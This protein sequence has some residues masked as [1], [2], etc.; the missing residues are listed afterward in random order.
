M[1]VQDQHKEAV[2][3][4]RCIATYDVSHDALT[5]EVRRRALRGCRETCNMQRCN[6]FL[7]GVYMHYV[8]AQGCYVDRDVEE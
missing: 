4:Q 3:S 8:A 2:H 1:N 7:Q 5:Y 6:A